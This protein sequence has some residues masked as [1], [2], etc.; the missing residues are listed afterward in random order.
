MT[1]KIHFFFIALFTFLC[2][3]VNAQ[4][5]IIEK[6]NGRL[7]APAGEESA[8]GNKILYSNSDDL[9]ITHNDQKVF[10]YQR[11]S[12]G[13]FELLNTSSDYTKYKAQTIT[14]RVN[15]EGGSTDINF[16]ESDYKYT[17]RDEMEVEFFD[18]NESTEFPVMIGYD[19]TDWYY[20]IYHNSIGEYIHFKSPDQFPIFYQKSINEFGEYDPDFSQYLPFNSR[21]VFGTEN[22]LIHTDGGTTY[23][24]TRAKDKDTGE[25]IYTEIESI[26]DGA[27]DVY[28]NADNP[29]YEASYN[30]GES[31]HYLYYVYENWEEERFVLFDTPFPTFED[32]IASSAPYL[33]QFSGSYKSEIP[34]EETTLSRTIS[35][36]EFNND[37]QQLL[38]GFEDQY[39]YQGVIETYNLSM[40]LFEAEGTLWDKNKIYTPINP[41]SGFGRSFDLGGNIAI[42]TD[43]GL[44]LQDI[45]TNTLINFAGTNSQ[46]GGVKY[47]SDNSSVLVWTEDE[48][49]IYHENTY[50]KEMSLAS[51]T[52]FT[53]VINDVEIIEN[54]DDFVILVTYENDEVIHSFRSTFPA[55]TGS[56]SLPITPLA[57]VTKPNSSPGANQNFIFSPSDYGLFG[58]SRDLQTLFKIDYN[59]ESDILNLNQVDV[60]AG[61]ENATQFGADIGLYSNLFISTSNNYITE[62]TFQYQT[63]N[64]GNWSST[65][66][67]KNGFIPLG[68]DSDVIKIN[69]IVTKD[70]NINIQASKFEIATTGNLT[71]PEGSTTTTKVD[72]FTNSGTLN[73]GNKSLFEFQ[74]G[75]NNTGAQI[76]IGSDNQTDFTG[77]LFIFIQ[78]DNDPR[79]FVNDGLI[80]INES[81]YF[82]IGGN[83]KNSAANN[84]TFT[85][86]ALENDYEYAT[87]EIYGEEHDM[88][89]DLIE[90]SIPNLTFYNYSGDLSVNGD[91]HVRHQIS[92]DGEN[93][94]INTESANLF[95]DA[96]IYDN[97]NV[98]LSISDLTFNNLV[99]NDERHYADY[100]GYI[101]IKNQLILNADFNADGNID[102][103]INENV[104]PIV[105]DYGIKYLSSDLQF[106]LNLKNEPSSFSVD[107]PF[108]VGVGYE[109]ISNY[110]NLPLSL[111]DVTPT[112]PSAAEGDSKIKIY[113]NNYF[114]SDEEFFIDD[115]NYYGYKN[116]IWHI[117]F[118]NLDQLSA[119]AKTPL[120][121][122]IPY[123][124][125]ELTDYNFV[126][127]DNFLENQSLLSGHSFVNDSISIDLTLTSNTI[128]LILT[129][130]KDQKLFHSITDG[131]WD[132][133]E[134]WD[135][136]DTPSSNDS[137]VIR[138]DV[139]VQ[140]SGYLG[141]GGEPTV[142][143]FN[144]EIQEPIIIGG[145]TSTKAVKITSRDVE[146][147]NVYGDLNLDDYNGPVLFVC[148]NLIIDDNCSISL[149]DYSTMI[150]DDVENYSGGEE[151][152]FEF[153]NAS[154][155][156]ININGE[157]YM[158]GSSY[159][160]IHRD[161]NWNG[162]LF[163]DASS[164]F[165]F[166]GD[167]ISGSE[168]LSVSNLTFNELDTD[169]DRV[170]NV[171]VPISISD[172][173]SIQSQG[174]LGINFNNG[175][176]MASNAVINSL[177][178]VTINGNAND[179]T[180]ILNIYTTEYI[181]SEV[182]PVVEELS[183]PDNFLSL[184][185][186]DYETVNFNNSFTVG[187]SLTFNNSNDNLTTIE[188]DGDYIKINKDGYSL[189]SPEKILSLNNVTS[190]RGNLDQVTEL[191]VNWKEFGYNKP[192][193]DNSISFG[194]FN[195]I[196]D[197]IFLVNPVYNDLIGN[198]ALLAQQPTVL[199]REKQLPDDSF[200]RT[201]TIRSDEDSIYLLIS[202][203]TLSATRDTIYND[204]Q[205]NV[206][207]N[208]DSIS[209]GT[210]VTSVEL[211]RGGTKVRA[212]SFPK[213]AFPD[214]NTNL[215]QNVE[216]SIAL[217]HDSV[218]NSE[219]TKVPITFLNIPSGYIHEV[220]REP[221]VNFI[222]ELEFINDGS[223]FTEFGW[224]ADSITSLFNNGTV[225]SLKGLADYI[226]LNGEGRVLSIDFSNKNISGVSF[227][228]LSPV[229]TPSSEGEE[230]ILTD[231]ELLNVPVLGME[232]LD[233]V[234]LEDNYLDFSDLS[235]YGE[236]DFDYNLEYTTPASPFDSYSFNFK[237][238]LSQ[239]F[240]TFNTGNTYSFDAIS[241]V[242]VDDPGEV[243]T[244]NAEE[245]GEYTFTFDYSSKA[246]GSHNYIITIENTGGFTNLNSVPE[247]EFA[248]SATIEDGEVEKTIL[249]NFL[250]AL[251]GYE[252]ISM[253][254]NMRD[255]ADPNDFKIDQFGYVKEI[256]ISNLNLTSVPSEI[257][258]FTALDELN[259][260]TNQLF[261]DDIDALVAGFAGMESPVNITLGTSQTYIFTAETSKI[262]RGEDST[263]VQDFSSYTGETDLIYNWYYDGSLDASFTGN[264]Y[265][266]P[267][268][269]E[270][271][272]NKKLE[273]ILAHNNYDG[274]EIK[275]ADYT[276]EYSLGRE[277]SVTL[278]N[279]L[280]EIGATPDLTQ[281][282]RQWLDADTEIDE[283]G[284]V[285]VLDLAGYDLASIPSDVA[286]LNYLENVDI[287]DNNLQDI[288]LS[289]YINIRGEKIQF[290]VDDNQLF[291]DD[292]FSNIDFI[293]SYDIQTYDSFTTENDIITYGDSYSFD[294]TIP[295]LTLNY[296][297]TKESDNS[298]LSSPA[299]FEV[300]FMDPTFADSYILNVTSNDVANLSIEVARVNLGFTL[301]QEDSVALYNLFVD[302]GITPDQSL[303]MRE[304]LDPN[305]DSIATKIDDYGRVI[306][307][308][309][310][311]R[312]L[313]SIPADV[314]S[315]N[316]LETANFA[317]NQLEDIDLTGYINNNSQNTL[318]NLDSNY[319]FFDEITANNA[320]ISSYAIQTYSG[321]DT[322]TDTVTYGASFTYDGDLNDQTLNYSWIKVSD[323]SQVSQTSALAI[324]FME[325]QNAGSYRLNVTSNNVSDLNILTKQVDL[326][327]TLGQEDSLLLHQMFTEIGHTAYDPSTEFRTWMPDRIDIDNYGRV[328]A[329]NLAQ[330]GINN[331]DANLLS[332]LPS[333]LGSFAYLTALNIENNHLDFEDLATID[334]LIGITSYTPQLTP[335]F[336][337]S[338]FVIQYDEFSKE[339]ASDNTREY[340]WVFKGDTLSKANNA[341]LE[342]FS[343]DPSKEGVYQLVESAPSTPWDELKLTIGEITLN[344]QS[345]I[346]EADSIALH[347]LFT[348]MSVDFDDNERIIDWPRMEYN[349]DGHI[350]A[351][352]LHELNGTDSLPN[353]IAQFDDL[354]TLKLYNSNI[355]HISDSLWNINTLEYLDLSDNNL[356][357]DDVSGLSKLSN[358]T[359]L[360]LSLNNL[361]NIPDITGNF[362]LRYLIM[363]DNNIS[364]IGA[365]FNSLFNLI[366][367]SFAGNNI[368]SITTDFSLLISLKKLDFS[369][370]NLTEWTTQLPESVEELLLYTNSISSLDSISNT[371]I[372]N[373][374][375]N[376]LFYNDLVNFQKEF[377]N[378]SPQRYD[379]VYE[380]VAMIQGEN[381]SFSHNFEDEDLIYIWF[382]DGVIIDTLQTKDINLVDMKNADAGVY[383]CFVSH[384]YWTDL[385]IQTAQIS[386][387]IN[388]GND[389]N[390]SI[391]TN[392]NEWF[393]EGEDI[394]VQIE[395]LSSTADLTYIW[396]KGDELLPLLNTAVVSV[397]EAGKY[398]VKI[399]NSEGCTSFSDS[400]E[401]RVST[402]IASP[403]IINTGDSLTVE[404]V[405]NDLQY[406]WYVDG[407]LIEESGS[408]IPKRVSGNYTVEVVNE[409]GCSEVSNMINVLPSEI[410]TNLDEELQELIS[411]YPQPANQL[412][413]ISFDAFIQ[414]DKI[415]LITT[416]GT[417]V[418][419]DF[420]QNQNSYE[421]PTKTLNN[422]IY[423]LELV[424]KNG[425]TSY[426]KVLIAH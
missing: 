360:W 28:P 247:L 406:F 251:G 53:D 24:L 111:V 210:Q 158:S 113:P 298:I 286:S 213:S 368:E 9:I 160:E 257:H 208:T 95:I 426:H 168:T 90:V 383:T 401:V 358:L 362:S 110:F 207:F 293:S 161:I 48:L 107:I 421:V 185:I 36:I 242:N 46:S 70:D 344:Y 281:N 201:N 228:Q 26:G 284:R 196:G 334:A 353:L 29:V 23:T 408:I 64:D 125:D 186:N 45:S 122:A 306:S 224:E 241:V 106:Y 369:R 410:I 163:D 412:L 69:N 295:G 392:S 212:Y 352:F 269:N 350:T 396:Y 304:W 38:L 193:F 234:T 266:V 394:D 274:L 402:P 253:A 356:F 308:D 389:L 282:M 319:L 206:Y 16:V 144:V 136:Y 351:L 329:L 219:T 385:S 263:F 382:K 179:D 173:G 347:Q 337:E 37:N 2:F 157:I 292:I 3:S 404:T 13:D 75:A 94:Y 367:L 170:I 313:S 51:V 270:S 78:Y 393:C 166:Y 123:Y 256:N 276:F 85:Y 83:W 42:A 82:S 227:A 191:E 414:V 171:N 315:F 118:E 235:V 287:S 217:E 232:Y 218:T 318:F 328:T 320:F 314:A 127:R 326:I 254:D 139:S 162:T 92:A 105:G 35:A 415:S 61:I 370:N 176:S 361:S 137:V 155:P 411:L 180:D 283:Y 55:S 375:D 250:T 54:G 348:R 378:Y 365:E 355:S 178:Y 66:T 183:T 342:V 167:I 140:T 60:I 76:F 333:Q 236:G 14:L 114:G 184:I 104:E 102:L 49:A 294:G 124:I 273:L 359:T 182:E 202:V 52:T 336:T 145:I 205:L 339:Y 262:Y 376:K 99:I 93:D 128:D 57:T 259:V 267:S 285:K 172:N 152:I 303:E 33:Q 39:F 134:T 8:F 192:V 418:N 40:E 131:Q 190:I 417:K 142:G 15:D 200:V 165:S 275:V 203:N 120:D 372:L 164:Q 5:V 74:A 305:N 20:R 290:K 80:T 280:V 150:L 65:T 91:L 264:S 366:D 169:D 187:K 239:A 229:I 198:F 22:L 119:T 252:S 423:L 422:G 116:R 96:P 98:Y 89:V 143:E 237:R 335:P 81:G 214:L 330:F 349:L 34:T 278:Y 321:Y 379:V 364:S 67:W 279:I 386:I 194:N 323:S 230:I 222:N 79:I 288:T 11:N 149:S 146:G 47:F 327:F 387:G 268:E 249:F 59:F 177:G 50:S 175:F 413:N 21:I 233:T 132:Y 388:C 398:S 416:S 405:N 395:A 19:G 71:I 345:L 338:H 72:E 32:F 317:D 331:D 310:S 17:V 419:V 174:Q 374:A 346:S 373:V 291:F 300:L 133:D 243:I 135:I 86:D 403:S 181:P 244:I 43:Q 6:Q 248:L 240:Y 209:T 63:E 311:S 159:L 199:H 138:H 211:D 189:E 154:N 420:T 258:N 340:A 354:E 115:I 73:I 261:F 156:T 231:T 316:Y 296:T 324:P 271:Y 84:I 31:D 245:S 309:L 325:S 4:D 117:D 7:T 226:V 108:L 341:L 381:Y 101:S 255:W 377:L 215:Y 130:L 425:L 221:L 121:G 400:I 112:Y 332:S 265:T 129:S 297:W 409:S 10:T 18:Y 384:P 299:L 100:Y 87:L 312:M 103:E 363:D 147:E 27:I 56:F 25:D 322:L 220:D 238:D 380:N 225:S 109:V 148:S 216:F 424:Q 141:E 62:Y 277:D 68:L 44:E 391:Q 343:F 1:N 371:I 88:N 195:S 58:L 77:A 197:T 151:P 399:Q 204:E 397:H 260:S 302:L 301:G 289:T 246:E 153:K 97:D 126:L 30:D 272:N 357:D 390:V 41:V 407:Q 307:L 223:V 188:H 12:N